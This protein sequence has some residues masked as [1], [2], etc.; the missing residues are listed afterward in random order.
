MSQIVS[1]YKKIILRLHTLKQSYMVIKSQGLTIVQIFFVREK[2]SNDLIN[3]QDFLSHFAFKKMC[4]KRIFF[5]SF[6]QNLLHNNVKQE[7]TN[8][9]SHKACSH[10]LNIK[11]QHWITVLSISIGADIIKYVHSVWSESLLIYK[12]GNNVR[13]PWVSRINLKS[14][15]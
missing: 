5:L 8:S 9:K 15:V 3:N 7:Q 10:C 12:T 2:Q 4:S 13:K 1:Y 11:S 14:V 6:L